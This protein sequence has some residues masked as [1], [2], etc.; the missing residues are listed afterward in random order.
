[1]G[2]VEGEEG[3]TEERKPKDAVNPDAEVGRERGK[4]IDEGLDILEAGAVELEAA[5][6]GGGEQG[7]VALSGFDADERG[8]RGEGIFPPVTRGELGRDEGDGRAGIDQEVI[9]AVLVPFGLDDEVI[10]NGDGAE[11]DHR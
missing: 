1:M 3:L 11:G 4:V 7:G 8:V 10:R 6:K 2:V 9:G 5:Q